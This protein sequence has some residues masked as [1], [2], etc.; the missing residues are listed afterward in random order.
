LAVSTYS[1]VSA[2]PGGAALAADEVAIQFEVRNAGTSSY[3]AAPGGQSLTLSYNTPGGMHQVASL[4][5]PP[6]A[7]GHAAAPLAELGPQQTWTGYMRATLT[8]ADRRWPLH[9]KIQYGND[10]SGLRTFANDCNTDNNE[11]ILTRP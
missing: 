9:L 10:P 1:Y 6:L 11:I 7:N 5:L 2:I 8:P 3:A 4:V